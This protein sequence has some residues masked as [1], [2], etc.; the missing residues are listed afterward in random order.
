[1]KSHSLVT[2]VALMLLF[3]ASF[4]TA[5]QSGH[6]EVRT[7]A[8]TEEVTLDEQGREQKRLVPVATVT[9]GAEVVYTVSFANVSEQPADKVTVTNPIP[10]FMTYVPNS[11]FGP[12]T[13][14]SFSID[15]GNS[16]QAA[17]LLTVLDADGSPRAAGPEDYTHVRWV[18]KSELG[19][20]DQG[21]ARFR[22]V[23]Q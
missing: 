19:A 11:A 22:A 18:L 10:D 15:G 13:E 9:P 23:L 20:G 6:I 17:Q 14:V 12:G 7:V 16:Y 21:F 3:G 4:A 5:Q 1:M 8:E 2:P